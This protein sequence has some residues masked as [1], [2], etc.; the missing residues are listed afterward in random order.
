MNAYFKYGIDANKI[1]I[2][3]TVLVLDYETEEPAEIPLQIEVKAP[4]EDEK[5]YTEPKIT[6]EGLELIP[7]NLIPKEDE[8][9]P[10]T[11][12]LNEH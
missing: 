2:Q 6:P 9:K 11:G 3:H 10:N 1:G 7:E 4:P 8:T 12:E 5:P